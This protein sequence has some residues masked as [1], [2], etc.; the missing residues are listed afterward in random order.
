MG[1][2]RII[3]ACSPVNSRHLAARKAA[4]CDVHPHILGRMRTTYKMVP[5]RPVSARSPGTTTSHATSPKGFAP[6]GSLRH[7]GA[8]ALP[9]CA[10]VSPSR[11]NEHSIC[12][13]YQECGAAGALPGTA[14]GSYHC[15]TISAAPQAPQV[16]Q[17]GKRCATCVW[18]GAYKQ[19]LTMCNAALQC[20]TLRCCWCFFTNLHR[21]YRASHEKRS[22]S[23]I[24]CVAC[25]ERSCV[26]GT[27]QLKQRRR[28]LEL[29]GA[30]QNVRILQ[31]T[32]SIAA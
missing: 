9:A 17:S 20:V 1:G 7:N 27:T 11:T 23:I 12:G 32:R 29:G 15:F 28:R 4:G 26:V 16:L 30:C 6:H 19:V 24:T 10:V 13:S 3:G 2:L 8:R 22:R 31:P 25:C 18:L 14:G 21:F 5:W